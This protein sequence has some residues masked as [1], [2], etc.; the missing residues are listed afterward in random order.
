VKAYR[1]A[2]ILSITESIAIMLLVKIDDWSLRHNS[3]GINI[4][5]THVIA[6]LNIAQ[7][8]Y[9]F[10]FRTLIEILEIIKDSGAFLVDLAVFHLHERKR[11]TLR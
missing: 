4:G 11:K 10:E 7:I 5:H 3:I 8:A 9:R 2:G 1:N 6:A